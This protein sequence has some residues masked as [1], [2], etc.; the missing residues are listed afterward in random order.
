MNFFRDR[1]N[2]GQQLALKL[3]PFKKDPHAI[4]VALPRGGVVV[5]KA[6]ADRLDLPLEITVPRK[7]SLPSH[8]E[9]AL[10]AIT[11][12]GEGFFNEALLRHYNFSL[13][14]IEEQV[15]KEKKE[16]QRRLKLYRAGRPPA[17]LKD[18]TVILVDD[19]IATGFTT[20]AALHSL[21]KQHPKKIIL[22]VPVAPPELK[23]KMEEQVDTLVVLHFPEPFYAVGRFYADFTQTTDE[24]VI[25]LLTSS[26]EKFPP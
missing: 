12:T 17:S 2:A 9:F 18:K 23:A 4:V 1:K 20:V 8:P 24:E 26:Y 10:G 6:I 14:Q 7:I 15:E 19:G 25:Q 21:R 16:A 11:E 22:A 3:S 13:A 5:G